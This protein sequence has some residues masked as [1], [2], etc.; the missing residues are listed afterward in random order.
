MPEL[1]VKD[2]ITLLSVLVSLA[3]VVIGPFVTLK[4]SKRQIVSPIRQKWIDEL[5]E[6]VSEYLSEC[7]KLLVLGKD[8]MLNT[9]AIDEQLFTR[10]LYLEQK[11]KL[12]LNPQ[13]NDHNELLEIIQNLAHDIHHGQ[14]DPTIFGDRMRDATKATQIILK[15]E[16]N[17]VKHGNI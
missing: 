7:E 16:W 1:E 8:G 11:L 2:Y 15:Q 10:L 13:E 6:V 3:A 17:R 5:R 12:M 4:I 14:N 9:E